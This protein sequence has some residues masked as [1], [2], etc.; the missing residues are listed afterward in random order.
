MQKTHE[1]AEVHVFSPFG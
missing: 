1:F